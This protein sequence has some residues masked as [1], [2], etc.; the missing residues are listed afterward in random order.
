MKESGTKS[1]QLDALRHQAEALLHEKP[2]VFSKIPPEDI[3]QLIH[4][5]QVHQIE[6]EIQNDEQNVF[7]MVDLCKCVKFI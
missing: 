6:L 7:R 4:E 1:H 3:Q 2:H 5:L